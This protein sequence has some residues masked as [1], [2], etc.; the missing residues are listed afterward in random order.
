MR[1]RLPK[2]LHQVGGLPIIEHVMAEVRATGFGPIVVVVGHGADD[3]RAAVGQDV[4]FAS[5]ELQLGTGHAVLSA[6]PTLPDVEDILVVY[7]ECP[8]VQA[9]TLTA[10]WER[11]STSGAVETIVTGISSDPTGI[12]R[13]LRDDA[14]R[15]RA[16]VEEAVAS[17]AEKAIREINGGFCA[18]NTAFLRQ[19]LASLPLRPKGEYYLTDM[20]E[21]AVNAGLPVESVAADAVEIVGVNDRTHLALAESVLRQRIC[22][23]H[24]LTGVTIVDP[25]STYIGRYVRIGADTI[26]RPNTH[27]EGHTIVG[28]DC[29]LGPNSQI[30]DSRIGD[31]CRVWA[32]VLESATVDSDVRIGPMSHLRPDAHVESGAYVG[33]YAEIKHSR[34]GPHSHMHHFSYLG[35]ADVGANVNLGAGTITCNFNTETGVKSR[36]YVG[37]GAAVGSDTMLVAPVSIGPGAITGAGSVVTRDV[38]E[39]CVVAGV[40]ARRLRP[41]RRLADEPEQPVPMPVPP[42]ATTRREEVADDTLSAE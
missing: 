7:G 26:V 28:S 6:L 17:P 31:R 41:V 35:D 4:I 19:H 29:D 34:L 14:G 5:Q 20:L 33:N 40:P 10:I 32:S 8:L 13:I 2:V 42:R 11:H 30:V 3:V 16:I 18:F 37:D 39:G 27:L 9:S 24:M 25:A 38:P 21:A 22:T 23:R 15:V 12:G 1:S 36:T